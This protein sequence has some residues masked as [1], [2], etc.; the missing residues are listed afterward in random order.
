MLIL[1]IFVMHLKCLSSEHSEA[2]AVVKVLFLYI[3]YLALVCAC[4]YHYSQVTEIFIHFLRNGLSF[5]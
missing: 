1:V 3:G 4:Y 5:N 2:K